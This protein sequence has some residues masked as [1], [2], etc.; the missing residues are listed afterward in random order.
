[1][2]K[3]NLNFNIQTGIATYKNIG[4]ENGDI[5][6]MISRLIKRVRESISNMDNV[7]IQINVSN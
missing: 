5:I 1:M 7:E 6:D 2:S 3:I 4:G